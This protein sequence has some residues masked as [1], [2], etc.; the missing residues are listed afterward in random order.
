VEI[1]NKYI[2]DEVERRL[3]QFVDPL[4]I[5]DLSASDQMN[6]SPAIFVLT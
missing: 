5:Q 3:R 6:T 2:E 1:R 4:A